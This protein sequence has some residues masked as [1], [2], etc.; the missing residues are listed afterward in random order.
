MKYRLLG[1]SG[2][3]VSELSLGTMTFGEEWGWGSPKE[4]ARKVYEAY[5]EAGGNFFDT[6]NFIL[7]VRAS[8]FL[9]SLRKATVSKWCSRRNIPMGHLAQMPMREAIIAKT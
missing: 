4:E 2:L 6:A 1:N 8:V 9:A 5:R 3:R 7:V